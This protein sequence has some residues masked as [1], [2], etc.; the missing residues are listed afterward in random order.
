MKKILIIAAVIA[1]A[2]ASCN[3]SQTPPPDQTP[4][5]TP[6]PTAPAAQTYNNA[7]YGFSFTYPDE[8]HFVTP[9]YAS[10]QDQIVQVQLAGDQYPGTNFGDAAFTVSAQ[11]AASLADC[12]KL[13]PPE[14][15]DG[16]KTPVVINGATFYKTASSGAGAGNF[17][18]ST[19]YRTVNAPNGA[20]IELN[21]TIHTSKIGNYP[22][23][24]VTEVDKT[25][26]Q[27][28]LDALLNSFQFSDQ[29]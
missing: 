19:V 13:S 7:T 22:T 10:L 9:T 28:R 15:G 14:N 3:N 26:V 21:E 18:E 29:Q 2:A 11:Y 6:T 27:A 20:C 5:P 24:T 4:T 1:L 12:L 17:Y 23:G 8:W 16:F 25:A